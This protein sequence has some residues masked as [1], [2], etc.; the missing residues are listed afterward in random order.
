[1][2][3]FEK[4]IGAIKAILGLIFGDHV[5]PWVFTA[6]GY[7]LLLAIVLVAV[8][9]L[10]V[11]VSKIKRLWFEEFAPLF[12]N[13]DEKRRVQRRQRFA[14]HVE[15]E[16]RRLNNLEVWSDYRFAELE[17]EVEAEGRRQVSGFL[18][19][20]PRTQSGLRRE[21]S[22]SKALELSRERLIL[23]EG[24]P[25]SGKSVALRHVAQSM[26]KRAMKAR[27]TKVVIPIYIN[28]KELERHERVMSDQSYAMAPDAI[29]ESF[30]QRV[31]RLH[32]LLVRRLSE[33]ELRELCFRLGVDYENLPGDSKKG[34]ARELVAHFERRESITELVEG[35]SKLYPRISWWNES[36]RITNGSVRKEEPIDKNLIH[37]FVLKS[38]NRVNDRDI[39]EF[40][41]E[42]FHRGLKEGT[43]LFLFDSFDELPEVLSST[44]A[45]KAIRDYA[46]AISDSLHG[47][48]QCRGVVASRQ[49]R[50]PGQLG[51][52]RFRILPLSDERRMELM[53]KADLKPA[54]ESEL[55]GRVGVAREEIRSMAGNPMF[56]GLLC[57]HVRAGHPF[58][59]NAHSVFETY[60]QTRLTR[61]AER[62]QRRFQLDPTEVRSVAECVAFCMAA[63]VG[64]G[65]S[66]ARASI[67]DSM[68]RLGFEV[69]TDF[70]KL[71]DALEYIKLARSEKATAAGESKPF[72]F[73][74][75]RFQEY[76]ATCI[77]LREPERVTP[78]QLLTDARW[79]ETAVV[80][81]QT[82][83]W[84]AL[85]PIIE[86]ARQLFVEMMT[87]NPRLIQD[88][89]GYVRSMG[90]IDTS[91]HTT[92]NEVFPE[93]FAWP[94]GVLHILR[95]LQDGFNNRLGDL[96]EDI[97]SYSGSLVISANEL[98][99]I[100]D[101]KWALEAAGVVPSP[102]L[103]WL[104][105][106]A[107]NSGS[108]WL[109]EVAYRQVARLT[110][111]PEY[112]AARI[113]QTL[114]EMALS[115]RLRHER[116]ATHAHLSRLDKARH[117]LSVLQLLRWAP[118]IDLCIHVA[119]SI[120]FLTIYAKGSIIFQ[121]VSAL[122]FFVFSYF[123]FWW[124]TRGLSLLFGSRVRG[125]LLWGMLIE[126]R[127]FSI[128]AIM[129][130]WSLSKPPFVFLMLSIY[131]VIW[132]LFALVSAR[133][134]QFV[135]L[136][137]WPM[138]PI[139]LVLASVRNVKSLLTALFAVIKENWR[140]LT[141]LVALLTLVELVRLWRYG[142]FILLVLFAALTVSIL[143]FATLTLILYVVDWC[144]WHLWV[145]SHRTSI[146]IWEFLG[147]LSQRYNKISCIQFTQIVRELGLIDATEETEFVLTRLVLA[148]EQTRTRLRRVYRRSRQER[149]ILIARLR[150]EM[151]VLMIRLALEVKEIRN[152]LNK[153]ILSKSEYSSQQANDALTTMDSFEHWVTEFTK[154]DKLWLWRL[155]PEFLDEVCMLLEQVRNT[156]EKTR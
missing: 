122:G 153:I 5:P 129:T 54:L 77:A 57:E 126:I 138:L 69:K 135:H 137:W 16:I 99:T 40:L 15:S 110:E 20:L 4:I 78:R 51:W 66:P 103:L 61:D 17:A 76:F 100:S 130:L 106:N 146:T 38:L 93:P 139:A 75:R 72:T 90:A 86:Q 37:S 67:N 19:F 43:W 32:E 116:H 21:R 142:L 58:P 112:I 29:S 98:G 2:P 105:R 91:Q 52:P 30:R 48:N 31:V 150:M 55:I 53:H 143:L 59:E 132:I 68:V 60:I 14:D 96:S 33:D 147:S 56:L 88:P 13:P 62:L 104:L 102:V 144:R 35:C 42:E 133:T 148:I 79:R 134:R 108:A 107:F 44:E 114:I 128:L 92:D 151:E 3:D 117:F 23:L 101:K 47:M 22:L 121:W 26:A 50:G 34:K 24:E 1:M 49:F 6:V 152:R 84:E 127:L 111:I 71:L 82:Q 41:E 46:D 131:A 73:A 80:M 11:V 95:L 155:E 113:R 8:W 87:S 85:A 9:R 70:D 12:Y 136:L 119:V 65:L 125:T 145:Q 18:S 118:F 63:D 25:G 81:C 115:G 74:H 97:R 156:R 89:L 109:G 7:T 154:K 141:L 123:G 83:R 94:R 27:S 28:L 64:L 39:E 36:E 10:L 45:D 149:G 120:T 124:I 140:D